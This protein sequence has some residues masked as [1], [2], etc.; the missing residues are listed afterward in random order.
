MTEGDETRSHVATSVILITIATPTEIP[1]LRSKLQRFKMVINELR[2][3]H[4][5]TNETMDA[6]DLRIDEIE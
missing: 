5:L 4:E 2:A 6:W 3:V 1:G